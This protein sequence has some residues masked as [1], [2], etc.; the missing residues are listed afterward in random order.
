MYCWLEMRQDW[1]TQCQG[2]DFFAVES[3]RQAALAI[4]DCMQKDVPL[5][6]YKKESD[7]YM[8]G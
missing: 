6:A 7:V 8:N 5:T 4:I 2:R 3:G 1:L